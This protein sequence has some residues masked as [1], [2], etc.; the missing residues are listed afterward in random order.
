MDGLQSV[1][2]WT[3]LIVLSGLS[4]YFYFFK[5]KS[6]EKAIKLERDHLEGAT[7]K[8]LKE[9]NSDTMVLPDAEWVLSLSG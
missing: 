5:K 8:E 2:M 6:H 4:S 1:Y 7:H 3:A 9:E